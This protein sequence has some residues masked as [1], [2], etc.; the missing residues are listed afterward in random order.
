MQLAPIPQSLLDLMA[1]IGPNWA[2]DV[3]GHIAMMTEAFS[4][5][6]RNSPDPGITVA[7][8]IAYGAHERQR[9][10]IY[11]M[12][13]AGAPPRPAL[14]FVHG[15]AFVKGDRDKTPEIYS[16]VLRYFA[17]RGFVGVNIGYRLADAASY[18]GATVDIA[19][20]VGWVKENAPAWN[21]DAGRIFLMG[22]SAGG[23]HV[24]SY[25]FDRRHQPPDGHGLAGLIVVS[26]RVRPD[27][28]RENPNAAKVKAYYGED[29]GRYDDYAAASHVAA[30]SVPTF[31]AWA[32][33]ENPLID[34]HCAE[35][36]HRLAQA[37]RRSPPVV[38]LAGHNHTS[39]IAHINTADE[40][41]ARQILEFMNDPK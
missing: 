6:L 22:H 35:L 38:W 5:V 31:V 10:D 37:K 7:R 14:L 2:D 15:G 24:A 39:S 28:M 25:A 1:R 8:D 33:Y 18:P 26:G 12:P 27:V 4:A 40:R 13:G 34:L 3:G 21:I 41:F 20:A 32:E 19:A 11:A 16:N 23:A 30:D 9:L 29:T 36:V 17:P